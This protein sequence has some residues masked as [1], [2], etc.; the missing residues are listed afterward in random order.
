M[1]QKRTKVVCTLGPASESQEIVEEMAK[2]GMNVARLN[3]SHGS[4]KNHKML[5]KNVRAVSKKLGKPIA[6]LQD[7]QGPK[8]RV[9]KMPKHGIE[10]KKGDKVTITTK[11]VI[12][13]KGLIPTQYK[14]LP[15]DV[16]KDNTILIED[17]I[18]ELKVLSKGKETIRC[19]VVDGGIVKS[20]K[21]INVPGGYISANPITKKDKEDLAFGLKNDVDWVALSFV[22][23][24][25]DIYEL[26]ALIRKHKSKARIIAK[27]ERNEAVEKLEKIIKAA[28]G[29]MVARGDLGLEIPAEKVPVI[30][31]K[32]I[33]M[34]NRNGKPVITATQML[35]SMVNE[36]VA[37]RAEISDAA[38]AVFDHS[39]ALMLSNESAVGGYPIEAAGTLGKVAREVEKEMKKNQELCPITIQEHDLPIAN[40]TCLNACKLANDIEADY[41]V[42][43]TGSGYTAQHIAKHRIYIPIITLTNNEKV[44]NQLS[45]VWGLNEIHV[46]EITLKDVVHEV[47]KFLLKKKLVKKGSEVV[48]VCNASKRQKLISTI[49]A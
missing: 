46:C 19:R 22:R 36:P 13:K 15:G 14:K 28:D 41:I 43:V 44:R 31:K 12:G 1:I 39:D 24:E 5:I 35:Q 29:I 27:I 16:S 47:K 38:N 37:T 11:D 17:G 3:F 10:V 33:K 6:I 25:K 21:G 2:A 40:A 32:M 48:I 49:I 45:L 20:N 30:Q 18:I 8:I 4:Y 9:G 23:S 26:R 34:A 7:L 42:A